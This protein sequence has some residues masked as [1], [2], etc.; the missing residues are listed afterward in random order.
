MPFDGILIGSRVMVAKEA[1]TSLAVKE[2]IVATPGLDDS[3]WESSYADACGGV[4]TFVSEYGEK[5]HPREQHLSLLLSRKAEIIERIN[6]DHFRPWFGKKSDGRVVDIEEMTYAEVAHRLVETMYVRHQSRWIHPS[7]RSFAFDFLQR[8][9]HRFSKDTA[10][11]FLHICVQLD[12]APVD[13]V[14]TVVSTYPACQTQLI[15]SE[16]AQFFINLCHRRGQ[17]PAPFIPRIDANFYA[18]FMKDA[19]WQSEDLDTITDQDIQRVLVQ[20][21]PVAARYSTEVNEP[22]KDILDGIYH[23]QIAALLERYYGG[24]KSK[25]PAV[26]YLGAEPVV[27]TLPPS[28]IVADSPSDRIYYLPTDEALLPGHDTWINAICGTRKS[29]LHALLTAPLLFQGSRVEDNYVRRMMRPRTGQIVTVYGDDSG[30]IQSLEITSSRG[31][32]ELDIAAGSNG[33]IVLNIYQPSGTT[34]HALNLQFVYHPSQPTSSIHEI[35]SGRDDC[36]RQFYTLLW[37]GDGKRLLHA[38]TFPMPGDTIEVKDVLVTSNWVSEYCSVIGTRSVNYPPNSKKATLAPMDMLAIVSVDNLF[39][40]MTSEYVHNGLLSLVHLFNRIQYAD[41]AKLLKIGDTVSC[42]SDIS[43]VANTDAGKAIVVD[44]LIYREGVQI[45]VVQS[46]LLWRGVFIEEDIAYKLV[47]EPVL[48]VT[49]KSIENIKV[50]ETR[51]WF[52]YCE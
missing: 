29:W 38:A 52:V 10:F 3:E 8:I 39:K 51:E 46:S 44:I 14:S 22:V 17:K 28:V 18:W 45:A 23:G 32:K 40:S 41:G 26:E 35:M 30:M 25:V 7:Y 5:N 24:D 27:S 33:V 6:R 43:E 42:K 37:N 11:Y 34:T 19:V 20:Q 4:V 31:V 9:E 48:R 13:F 15:S 1:A 2:L 12:A 16:D 36:I 47:T 50:L 49:L 21:G